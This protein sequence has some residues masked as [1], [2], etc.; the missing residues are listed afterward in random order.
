MQNN[1]TPRLF[2][3]GE[4]AFA[5]SNLNILFNYPIINDITFKI[6]A[7]N[8]EIGFTWKEVLAKVIKFYHLLKFIDKSYDFNTEQVGPTKGSKMFNFVGVS[9][10]T[11]A[12]GIIGLKYHRAPDAWE[13]LYDHYD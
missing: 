5:T 4:I 8:D 6:Y 13:V 3:Q 11:R 2:K 7:D 10:D 9:E 12:I 1:Y